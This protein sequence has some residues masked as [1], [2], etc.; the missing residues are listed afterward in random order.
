[1]IIHI[2]IWF[3]G[4]CSTSDA[5]NVHFFNSEIWFPEKFRRNGNIFDPA[6]QIRIPGNVLVVPLLQTVRRRG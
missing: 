1:M 5:L 6:K 2:K 3:Y 4:L